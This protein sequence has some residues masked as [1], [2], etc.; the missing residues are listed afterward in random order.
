MRLYA[1]SPDGLAQ[2]QGFY[3]QFY[4]NANVGDRSAFMEANARALELALRQRAADEQAQ[5]FDISRADRARELGMEMSRA[6]RAAATARADRANELAQNMAF[7]SRENALERGSRERNVDRQYTSVGQQR[8]DQ[9]SSQQYIK[10]EGLASKGLLPPSVDEIKSQ[11]NLDEREAK[12]LDSINNLAKFESYKSDANRQF[13]TDGTIHPTLAENYWPKGHE[14]SKKAEQ[15]R[16][17]IL[18][19][20]VNDYSAAEE[21][22]RR[23]NFALKIAAARSAQPLPEKV[24]LYKMVDSVGGSMADAA[25]YGAFG[26]PTAAVAAWMPERRQDASG[27]TL[28]P[29]AEKRVAG[30]NDFITA[31]RDSNANPDV[32]VDLASGG[33]KPS[34]VNPMQGG[35]AVANTQ[36]PR[37]TGLA[38]LSPDV[39]QRVVDYLVKNPTAEAR[40]DFDARYGA[41]ASASILGN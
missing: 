8:A 12:A 10:A 38:S 18:E 17:A 16:N 28:N 24:G 30:V 6:D 9:I 35:S 22:A 3:D 39:R 41:G 13:H 19:P 1:S 33:F 36:V 11:F 25:R 27:V 15:F 31:L 7:T 34:F 21:K 2:Q 37:Q 20:A 5:S 40:R 23:G 32:S 26:L 29:D 14:F 4:H